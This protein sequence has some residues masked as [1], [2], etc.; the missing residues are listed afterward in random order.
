M[1]RKKYV[2]IGSFGAEG[3]EF[4]FDLASLDPS[5]EV[6]LF[7][8]PGSSV[9]PEESLDQPARTIYRIPGPGT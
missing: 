6:H 5:G 2:Y 3:V 1:K 9:E 7:G 4:F 8:H